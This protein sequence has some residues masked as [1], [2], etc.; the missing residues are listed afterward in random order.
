MHWHGIIAV[1][2]VHITRVANPYSL[3]TDLDPALPKKLDPFRKPHSAQ[4]FW[5]FSFCLEIFFTSLFFFKVSFVFFLCSKLQWNFTTWIRMNMD[6]CGSGWIRIH[7]DPL[8]LLKSEW[9]PQY[10]APQSHGTPVLWC[11]L[12]A[13]LGPLCL[14]YNSLSFLDHQVRSLSNSTTGNGL[15]QMFK[16]QCHKMFIFEFL[17]RCLILKFSGIH[18]WVRAT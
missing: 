4:K 12:N 6:P 1:V 9:K 5:S 15:A 8:P 17:L 2:L 18:V 13:A 11:V 14:C 16:G 7:A 10:D 3:L